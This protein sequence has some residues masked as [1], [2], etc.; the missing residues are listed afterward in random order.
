MGGKYSCVKVCQLRGGSPVK[1]ENDQK[2]NNGSPGEG[3]QAEGEDTL[4]RACE[5]EVLFAVDRIVKCLKK[6]IEVGDD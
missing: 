5:V 6:N 3:K 2:N 1:G 4:L